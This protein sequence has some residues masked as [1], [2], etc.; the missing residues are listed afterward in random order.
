MKLLT[1]LLILAVLCWICF[2]FMVSAMQ[3]SSDPNTNLYIVIDDS[4]AT[5]Y[6]GYEAIS[7]LKLDSNSY[8]DSILLSHRLK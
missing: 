5:V 8:L 4:V 1:N 6:D 2:L 7:V 3:T